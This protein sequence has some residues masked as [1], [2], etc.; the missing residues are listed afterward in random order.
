MTRSFASSLRGSAIVL[1][2]LTAASCSS[3]SE[4]TPAVDAGTDSPSNGACTA[5][6]AQPAPV[7]APG[8][9]CYPAEPESIKI[10][11]LPDS[12]QAMP[13]H[14]RDL[15]VQVGPDF[16][17]PTSLDLTVDDPTIV[18]ACPDSNVDLRH[19]AVNVKVTALKLGTTKVTARI[20]RGDGTF[21]T[22][23]LPIEV[24]AGDL[25][26][27][28]GTASGTVHAGSSF[29]GTAGLVGASVALPAGAA[30]PN[31]NAYLW[32][33][34][35]FDVSLGCGASAETPD[36]VAL[37]PAIS[38][39]PADAKGWTFPREIP[40]TIPV[41]PARVPDAGR[42]RH[43]QVWFSSPHYKEP[44]PIAV[45]DPHLYEEGGVW[46]MGFSVSALG[47]YQALVPKDAGAKKF[48]R[49]LTHR[50][51]IG[52]SMGGGG[53]A[54]FGARHHDKFD[55]L[56]PLGGPVDWTW[57]MHSIENNHIAGFRT[58]DGVTAPTT[59]ITAQELAQSEPPLYPYEHRQTF[60]QWWY[61]FPREGNGGRFARDEYTQIFRDLALMFGNPNGQND[62]PGAENLPAGVPPDS[63]SVVGDHPGHECQVW[64]DPIDGDPN[65]AKQ[66]ELSNQCP[67]ERCKPGNQLRLTNYYDDEYNSKGTWPVITVCDG[68]QLNNT[69]AE[70][71]SPYANTWLPDG[72]PDLSQSNRV[73]LEIGLAVDY[74]DDGVRQSNE[75]IIR[76]GHEP[77]KDFGTDGKADAD[78]TGYVKGVNE[79]PAGDDYHAQFN[80]SGTEG[81]GR[82]QQGE[83]YD[84]FG[85]DGVANTPDPGKAYDHG[86]GDGE[87]TASKGLATFWERDS[88]SIVRQWSTP[89]GGAF[90]DAALSRT[91]WWVDGGTRDLFNFAVDGQ[92]LVGALAARGRNASYYSK[93]AY[94]PGQDRGAA[95]SFNA[96][97][98]PWEDVP[99]VVLHRYGSVDP[100]AQEIKE[101][102]GQHVGTA[103]EVTQRLQSALYFIGSRWPDAPHTFVE[104]SQIDPADGASN[105]ELIGNCTV[106]F[107]SKGGR[108]GPVGITLPPGYAN[109]KQQGE[110]YPVIYLLHGYG[111]GPQDLEAAIVFLANW[112]NARTDTAATRLAKSI[113]VYVDGR[114]R[115]SDSGEPECIRGTFFTD[116]VRATGA[117]DETWW[118]E[119]MD[120]VDQNYRTMGPSDVEWKP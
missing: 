120:Y 1:A 47:T 76:A 42:L 2:C 36:L 100:S 58:N 24:R 69:A 34:D 75:P 77:W 117:Q 78:E 61:E 57:M 13:G 99:G 97:A 94:L 74:N 71:L 70:A 19:P 7:L 109:K 83:P 85:L 82:W 6:P 20:P 31:L 53:T 93:V 25:A 39:T 23:E 87:F 5:P 114:C 27:C 38:I 112:M 14:A 62:A 59:A 103:I 15:V 104:P 81:D 48:T 8:E 105:C 46:R 79:D 41:D 102:S 35:D 45:T 84:D 28:S 29:D 12:Y 30:K 90:D 95:D 72:S 17:S 86:E 119:L 22:A 63:K 118:L 26:A 108:T 33:V 55:V 73:P 107:K 4:E 40:I 9:V 98:I 91:D 60:N 54:M 110:R 111:Q 49:H 92:H 52:I 10:R 3:S 16:C 32:H 21:A 67:T 116:S 80:P 11:W 113:L 18:T 37:G 65:K 96:G 89:P 50:A 115:T 51:V 106:N 101:G 43:V 68:S 56:A 64:V 88:H 44:R 66:D